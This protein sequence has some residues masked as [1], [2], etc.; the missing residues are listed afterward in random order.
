MADPKQLLLVALSTTQ[1]GE[2]FN[3][4][5]LVKR[6]IAKAGQDIHDFVNGLGGRSSSSNLNY[7]AALLLRLNRLERDV[8][9]LTVE[10]AGQR[11][12]N[13]R[14]TARIAELERENQA[15]RQTNQAQPN[16]AYQAAMA[17]DE[18][19]F[20]GPDFR[21]HTAQQ[22]AIILLNKRMWRDKEADFLL[23]VSH[24]RGAPTERQLKWL[25]DLWDRY[26]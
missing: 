26:G 6:A 22:A 9:N 21:G 2:A 19:A 1:P 24:W 13:Q 20:V 5:A 16:A 25:K 8:T 4:L 3:A 7:D 10:L 23:S 11:R 17:S 18:R 12:S 14:H 15:L